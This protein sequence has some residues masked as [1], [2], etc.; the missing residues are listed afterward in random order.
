MEQP[1]FRSVSTQLSVYNGATVVM[2]GPDHRRPQGDGRQRFRSWA[3]CPTSAACSGSR[4][5]QSAKR[6]LVFVT[7]RL[8]DPA[9]RG[10]YERR[11][12]A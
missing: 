10:A 5:E 8:V 4:S 11:R 9:G 6:L 3:T 12:V 7:A 1:F 2:G